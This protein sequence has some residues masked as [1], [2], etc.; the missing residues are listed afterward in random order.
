MSS[1]H[2]RNIKEYLGYLEKLNIIKLK[3]GQ[4]SLWEKFSDEEVTEYL[5]KLY[6][7]KEISNNKQRELESKFFNEKKVFNDSVEVDNK[8]EISEPSVKTQQNIAEDSE[9]PKE[10]KP[11]FI[12]VK[13][14]TVDESIA[15]VNDEDESGTDDHY[16]EEHEEPPKRSAE[17]V[18][19]LFILILGIL[20]LGLIVNSS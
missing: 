1:I 7:K 17:Y 11:N 14:S 16:Y 15:D 2:K 6:S 12:I 3:L 13:N 18:L 19:V 4:M 20:L 5:S 9:H 10:Y 8:K